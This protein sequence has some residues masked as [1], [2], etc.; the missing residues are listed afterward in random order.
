M[1]GVSVYQTLY[2]FFHDDA[3]AYVNTQ[4]GQILAGMTFVL[5]WAMQVYVLVL[6]T[7]MLIGKVD[8]GEFMARIFKPI[9]VV[10]L[11][12]P[13]NWN[14]AIIEMFTRQIPEI[15]SGAIAGIQPG[16]INA[17]AAW[18]GLSN[19]SWNVSAQALKQTVGITLLG[20]RIM[21]YVATFFA[22]IAIFLC[23]LVW[24]LA[25]AT[26]FFAL[27]IGALLAPGILFR[28]TEVYFARWI[29]KCVGLS[30][31]SA[32]ALLLAAY[33]VKADA[34]FSQKLGHLPPA[35]TASQGFSLNAGGSEIGTFTA[36][37]TPDVQPQAMG[38]TPMPEGGGTIN[39]IGA[40][41]VLLQLVLAY[42]IGVFILASVSVIGMQIGNSSGFSA[43]PV[44]N[45]IG[46]GTQR[47]ANELRRQVRRR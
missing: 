38:Q 14:V 2:E 41:S 12:Q 27:P 20:E 19:F 40:V 24:L 5:R 9:I 18:D 17:A 30:I 1:G 42:S 23:F 35:A 25:Q 15:Y 44:I 8:F 4:S 6:G 43:A 28:T 33:I 31:T 21:I 13:G 10:A 46:R 34:Q 47:L 11:M 26:L 36:F 29:G 32:V 16:S 39:T 37:N 3:I 7:S 45:A 22:Q